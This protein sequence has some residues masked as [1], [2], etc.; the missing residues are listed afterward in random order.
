MWFLHQ[1]VLLTNDN[2][3]KRK[4][5]GSKKCCHCDQDETIQH[6]FFE[7]P[8]AKVVWWIAHLSFNLAPPKNITNLFDNWLTG[9]VKNERAQIQVGA[10][11]CLWALW[12]VRNN[13]IFN[14]AKQ[15]SFVQVIPLAI[16]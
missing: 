9:V 15:N 16:Y 13:Y 14:R 2:L 10:C 11:A 4:W 6:L 1:R 12:N 3:A 8:L 5:E 7:C